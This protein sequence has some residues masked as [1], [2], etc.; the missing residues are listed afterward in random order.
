MYTKQKQHAR[1][2]KQQQRIG[3][4]KTEYVLEDIIR[5]LWHAMHFRATSNWRVAFLRADRV[6]RVMNIKFIKLNCNVFN[7]ISTTNCSWTLAMTPSLLHTHTYIHT[8]IYIRIYTHTC[9]TCLHCIQLP[10]LSKQSAHCNMSKVF[11]WGTAV[12][13]LNGELIRWRGRV[14]M[15]IFYLVC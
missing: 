7:T 11:V 1:S 13:A 4:L 5:L 2:L 3:L 6:I 8:V 9:N 12:F 15:Y 14:K 10:Q